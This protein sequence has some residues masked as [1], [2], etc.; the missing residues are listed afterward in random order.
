[1]EEAGRPERRELQSS[2]RDRPSDVTSLAV[3]MIFS[4]ASDQTELVMTGLTGLTD[5]LVHEESVVQ[6]ISRSPGICV[7]ST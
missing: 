3:E 2:R 5:E 4:D 6:D 7:T 1:M